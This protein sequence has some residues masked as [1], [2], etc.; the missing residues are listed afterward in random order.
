MVFTAGEKKCCAGYAL[1]LMDVYMP[2][3]GGIEA[4]KIITQY[5]KQKQ[6]NVP[7]VGLVGS[8]DDDIQEKCLAVGMTEIG[9][10]S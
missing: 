10:F 7:I 4:T 9:I 5:Y 8:M 2:V 6:R 1:I 3:M